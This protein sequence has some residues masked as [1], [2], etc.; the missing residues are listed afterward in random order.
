MKRCLLT[1]GMNL[2]ALCLMAQYYAYGINGEVQIMRNGN[3]QNVFSSMEL[4]ST[5]LVKTDEYGNLTV[6]DRTNDKI[7]SMQS[8][9]AQPLEQL[10]QNA[11]RKT[12]N[13]ASEYIQG[14]FS[15]LFGREDAS[16]EKMKTIGG[17]TYRGEKEDWNIAGA[18]VYSAKPSYPV[19]CMLLDW[20]TMEVVESVRDGGIY[21][22]QM[23]NMSD[24]PLYMNIIY[25]D[26][27]GDTSAMLPLDE[28]QTM[29]HLYIP[30]F[31]NVRLTG[32]PLSFSPAG[33]MNRMTLVASPMPFDLQNVLRYMQSP[34]LQQTNM[35][36]KS[37]SHTI[38]RYDMKLRIEN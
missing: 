2:F 7:Y 4:R 21:I 36:G 28:R 34:E 16:L 15:K 12:P 37:S 24:T 10:I 31:S 9:E 25:T 30:A 14:I 35:S 26:E 1:I 3:W 18:L 13:P 5:D 23:N 22:L 17:V 29:L 11:Q 19:S 32:F 33:V 20:Q 27:K 8:P 6:L 38:G